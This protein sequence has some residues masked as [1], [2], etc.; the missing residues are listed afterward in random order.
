MHG[1]MAAGCPTGSLRDKSGM[2][3]STND[4]LTG[5]LLLEMALDTKIMVS[6]RQHFGIHGPVGIVADSAAFPDGLMFEHE[7]SALCKVTLAAG[8]PLS[9][10]G[11][12]AMDRISFVRIVAITA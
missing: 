1:L 7:R 3:H 8:I 2:V 6:L 5:S 12:S 9:G 10:E 4:E 11:C